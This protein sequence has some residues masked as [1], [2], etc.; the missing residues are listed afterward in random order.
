MVCYDRISPSLCEL[1]DRVTELEKGQEAAVQKADS[2]ERKDFN[3]VEKGCSPNYWK[4]D[5]V[6]P[7]LN[8]YYYKSKRPNIF[9]PA[10]RTPGYTSENFECYSVSNQVNGQHK[11]VQFPERGLR[12]STEIDLFLR[13]NRPT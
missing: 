11:G 12:K 5:T 2:L 7:G 8:Y 10:S 9:H 6:F 4:E 1:L 13:G 3:S